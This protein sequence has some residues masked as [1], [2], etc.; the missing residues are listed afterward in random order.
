MNTE[1]T[2]ETLFKIAEAAHNSSLWVRAAETVGKHFRSMHYLSSTV[3]CDCVVLN[4]YFNKNITPFSADKIISTIRRNN[5]SLYTTVDSAFF[6]IEDNFDEYAKQVLADTYEQTKALNMRKTNYIV[7]VI[8]L[9]LLN[10]CKIDKREIDVL[11]Y[12]Y[13]IY[14]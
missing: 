6:P 11:A 7:Y 3:I 1:F 12:G 4:I 14:K 13:S 8:S 2:E 5:K 9:D 10:N